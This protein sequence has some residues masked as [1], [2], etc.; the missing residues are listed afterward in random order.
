MFERIFLDVMDEKRPRVTCVS[1]SGKVLLLSFGS[2][3]FLHFFGGFRSRSLW[4]WGEQQQLTG[5]QSDLHNGW[6]DT[7]DRNATTAR[8]NKKQQNNTR[9]GKISQ[10]NRKRRKI[11]CSQSNVSVGTRQSHEREPLIDSVYT[12]II[13]VK[14]YMFSGCCI[15]QGLMADWL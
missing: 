2:V 3:G 8:N 7:A 4:F 6:R 10:N 11:S 13:P 5:M 9:K 1:P 12:Y 14:I 15:L